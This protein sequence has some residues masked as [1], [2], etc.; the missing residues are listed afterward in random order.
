MDTVTDILDLELSDLEI[1]M[2]NAELDNSTR[3]N[4]F[5]FL[6]IEGFI[7]QNDVF[8]LKEICFIDNDYKFHTLVK[9]PHSIFKLS[10]KDRSFINYTTLKYN[11]LRYN[12]GQMHINDVIHQLYPKFKDKIVLVRNWLKVNRLKHIFRRCGDFDCDDITNQGV[13]MF[14]YDIEMREPCVYHRKS[15]SGAH[16]QCA[17]RAVEQ[18]QELSKNKHA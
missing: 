11:G 1:A 16:Y 5:A 14:R 9:S 12:D 17:L 10:E 15:K 3:K 4:N 18:M 2:F 13:R 6:D 8:I 7:T